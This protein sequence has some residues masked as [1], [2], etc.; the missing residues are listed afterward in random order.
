MAF[1]NT[2]QTKTIPQPIPDTP[3]YVP[4]VPP[5]PQSPESGSNPRFAP[6]AH[7]ESTTMN[8]YFT[9]SENNAIDKVLTAYGSYDIAFKSEVSENNPYIVI[10]AGNLSDVNYAYIEYTERYYYITDKVMLSNNLWGITLKTD[11]L[12]SFKNSIRNTNAVLR[13][14]EDSNYANLDLN[15]GSF[16]NQD[17]TFTEIMIFP[18]GLPETPHNILITAGG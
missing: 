11:V 14:T 13:K 1:F 2:K 6:K 4:P 3:G 15:D 18:N 9:A 10:E 7:S 17:N 8:L 12:M 16:I 5:E